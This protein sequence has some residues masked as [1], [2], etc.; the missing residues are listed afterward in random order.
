VT[1]TILAPF[2]GS[3]TLGGGRRKRHIPSPNPSHS[4]NHAHAV[5]ILNYPLIFVLDH[6]NP[7]DTALSASLNAP[8]R[9]TILSANL[10]TWIYH[11]QSTSIY[12]V[13]T[14]SNNF[15]DLSEK[16]HGFWR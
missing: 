3:G 12:V 4:D 10:P 6:C 9:V 15:R 2:A 5:N 1:A 16:L 14:E 8:A 13:F 11:E 7:A